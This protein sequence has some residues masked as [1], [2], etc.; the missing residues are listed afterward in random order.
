MGNT[1]LLIGQF[2]ALLGCAAS[3][4]YGALSTFQVFVGRNPVT[5]F[6]IGKILLSVYGFFING[7]LYVVFGRAAERTTGPQLPRNGSA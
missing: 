5:D 2:V 3:I 6:M 7:A 1:F 4:Y